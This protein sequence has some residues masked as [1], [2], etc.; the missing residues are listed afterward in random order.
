MRIEPLDD[1]KREILAIV[2]RQHVATGA[3]V[4]SGA[5]ARHYGRQ[6]SSATVRND[7]AA[8]EQAGYLQQPHTS[9]GRTPT[10]RAY[11]FYAREVAAQGHLDLADERWIRSRLGFPAEDA[12]V[13]LERVPHV[14]AELCHG[15]GLILAPPL[16]ST[17]LDQVRFMDLGEQRVLAVVV[18][19]T[20]L[21]RD[22]VIRTREPYNADELARMSAYLNENFRG[23]TLAAM[24]REMERRVAA[25]RSRFLRQ[26]LALCRETFQ[27]E[28]AH[29][30]LHVEGVAHL[31]EQAEAATPEEWHEL[32]RTLEEKER[33]AELLERCLETPEQPVRI[34][35]GL[36]RLSPALGHF[37]LVGARFGRGG[38]VIG[39]L[40]LLGRARMDYDR[41]VT[42]V[43][44][45]AALFN[46]VLAEN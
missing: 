2:V 44:Y 7:M 8:L 21:V 36:E 14:L 38:G 17:A 43:S 24:R 30:A 42:A 10:E 4:A 32:L 25:D 19:R 3:P 9:A 35:V 16:A 13:L 31:S 46:R 27:P 34:V 6:V 45:V 11:E 41:A 29:G 28:A 22:K 33:L 37:A 1:R 40:G 5:V 15:V 39:S 26:A 23:W 20:G 18:T 12:E